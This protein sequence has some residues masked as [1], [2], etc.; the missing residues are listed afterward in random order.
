MDGNYDKDTLPQDREKWF[1]VDAEWF[2]QLLAFI[3]DKA[4]A[5]GSRSTK[6]GP[7]DNSKLADT[8]IDIALKRGL[9]SFVARRVSVHAVKQLVPS[10]FV[11][12]HANVSFLRRMAVTSFGFLSVYGRHY[13][14]GMVVALRSHAVRTF[15]RGTSKCQSA[16]TR[17]H[18]R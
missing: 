4:S 1:P 14:L 18:A 8:T 9:V 5:D 13:L 6:P 10:R 12:H 17:S 16:C 2:D 3:N 11:A 7:I 15:L